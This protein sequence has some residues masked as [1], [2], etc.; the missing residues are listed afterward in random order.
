MLKRPDDDIGF[1]DGELIDHPGPKFSYREMDVSAQEIIIDA[2]KYWKMGV[3]DLI[4]DPLS[5]RVYCD[6]NHSECRAEAIY[7][8]AKSPLYIRGQL[9]RAQRYS[10]RE[11]ALYFDRDIITIKKIIKEYRGRFYVSKVDHEDIGE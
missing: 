9:A 1:L 2:C 8:L 11:L 6:E 10:F 3:K 4:D 7:R 5:A